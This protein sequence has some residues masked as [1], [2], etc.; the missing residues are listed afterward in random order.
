M[1]QV[2]L[3][4]VDKEKCELGLAYKDGT[5][6]QLHESMICAGGQKNE[7]TCKGDG[8][9]PLV[10]RRPTKDGEVFVQVKSKF[11]VKAT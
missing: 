2:A 4:L 10:C 6:Y 3:P 9:G 7:D 8:G 1:K 5:P 11:T